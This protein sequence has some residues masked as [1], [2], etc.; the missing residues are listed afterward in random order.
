MA[1]NIVRPKTIVITAVPSS[2]KS[3]F[4]SQYSDDS[5]GG[6]AVPRK[7]KRLNH[8]SADEKLM[9]R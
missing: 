1:L 8:L 7:R 2:R 3:E 6:I 4:S 9:R 5:D